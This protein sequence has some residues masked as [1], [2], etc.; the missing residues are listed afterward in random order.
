MDGF[1]VRRGSG[2]AASSKY[3]YN[4]E[5]T[6]WQKASTGSGWANGVFSYDNALV[7]TLSDSAQLLAV[8]PSEA[9]DL[10][11]YNTLK[12]EVSSESTNLTNGNCWIGIS[13]SNDFSWNADSTGAVLP[14]CILA[15]TKFAAPGTISLSIADFKGSYYPVIMATR[16][17]M[18]K[19]PQVIR[20]K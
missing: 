14:S 2:N 20:E 3:L 5:S 6:G 9:V 8:A 12:V 15:S 10:T 1:V 13:S 17:K 7:L 16:T 4:G 18:I 11:D 19:V